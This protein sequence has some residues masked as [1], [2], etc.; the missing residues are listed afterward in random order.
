MTQ[1]VQFSQTD[2]ACI[3]QNHAQGPVSTLD[4]LLSNQR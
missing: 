3:F 4:L 2:R 1:L